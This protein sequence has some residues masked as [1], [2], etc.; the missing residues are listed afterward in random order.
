MNNDSQLLTP[1]EVATE[2]KLNLLTVY[3]Y[4]R[5]KKIVAIKL[6]R[7]YRISEEN[8]NKFIKANETY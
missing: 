4:I 5:D 3:K 1:Q 7:V 8:L 2:L 6:G